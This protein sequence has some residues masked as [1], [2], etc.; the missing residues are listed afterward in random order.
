MNFITGISGFLGSY[1]AKRLIDNGE[2]VIGIK[3]ATTRMDLLGDYANK[4]KWYQADIL[5]IPSLEL[6]M[7]DA[8]KVYHCAAKISFDKKERELMYKAHAEGTANIVNIALH[9]KIKKFLHVSSVAALPAPK[10]DEM[11]NEKSDWSNNPYPAHYGK[12]KFMAEREA[13]RAMAEGIDTI[14]VNPSTI[15]GAGYWNEGTG[16]FY[17]NIYNGLPFYTNGS[18]GFI[19]VR[20]VADCIIKLMNSDIKNEKFILSSENYDFKTFF[21]MIAKE[22]NKKPPYLRVTGILGNIAIISDQIQC[23]FS[24]RQRL[25]TKETLL[26]ANLKSTYDNTK[27]K[28]AIQ[29]EFI[30]IEKSIAATVPLFLASMA[31][32][33]NY[34]TFDKI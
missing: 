15:I 26:L 24:N 10:H 8:T 25:V 17:T 29:H 7:K 13:Y 4:I 33:K 18:V 31:S 1:I 14:I 6:A 11:I 27:I 20:D 12:S 22:L 32:N 5:D 19:D 2:P 30:P 34:H 3:R 28:S 23:F 21:G 9:Y 16:N